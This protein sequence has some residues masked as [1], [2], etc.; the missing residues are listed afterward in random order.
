MRSV[1]LRASLP[2][3]RRSLGR[4]AA[5]VTLVVA[6]VVASPIA[7]AHE[8]DATYVRVDA[9]LR[10]AEA[11]VSL[12]AL[13]TEARLDADGDGR[14]VRSEL[15]AA[16]PRIG[17]L[18]RE[19]FRPGS[20]GGCSLERAREPRVV[21][22][23]TGPYLRMRVDLACA[24]SPP[25]I[26]ATSL[27]QR[28][29][30][31]RV[32]VEWA[33]EGVV[34]LLRDDPRHEFAVTNGA[35]ATPD[36]RSLSF[37]ADGVHHLL[38]GWDHVAFVF[39]LLLGVTRAGGARTLADASRKAIAI[40]TAFTAA[41]SLTLALAALGVLRLPAAPVEIAIAVTVLLTAIA[42]AFRH[43]ALHGWPVAF[44]FGLVHGLGFASVLGDLLVDTAV[45][46]PLLAFNLGIEAGQLAIAAALVP[47]LVYL[48]RRA[49]WD[50][51]AAPALSLGV[52]ALATGWIWQRMP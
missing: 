20:A 12:T 11:D 1:L 47:C 36:R 41:H 38:T 25:A 9:A 40:V 2:G 51:V 7:H 8:I 35:D 46:G 30:T 15:T 18:V 27:F 37:F 52:A 5:R 29:S 43:G 44:C 49:A 26:D 48:S 45:G 23:A 3:A 28:M 33:P 22:L 50:R 10:S 31:H 21:A 24:G 19:R 34:V 14:V 32:Y 4:A 39:L 17:A 16:M 42:V 6:G 13:A